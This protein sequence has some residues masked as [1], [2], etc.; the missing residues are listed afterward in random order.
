VSGPRVAD[1]EYYDNPF[2]TGAAGGA[3]VGA[4]AG[5]GPGSG[6]VGSGLGTV[7]GIA[8]LPGLVSGGLNYLSARESN[9]M[10]YRIFKEA[11]EFN[12]GE[13][14]INRLFQDSQGAQQRAFQERMSSTAYQ[15]ATADMKAAGIN[16][17]LA[18]MQGGASS[19]SG[20]SG[21]GAQASSGSAHMENT[22]MGD[23]IKES[24][25]TAI[26]LS[27]FEK[28]MQSMDASISLDKA[29]ASQ[30]MA[31]E[32][33]TKVSAKQAQ[34]TLPAIKEEAKAR[35]RHGEIDTTL[36][37]LDAG[38]DRLGSIGSAILSPI[39]GLFGGGSGK[40]SMS[41]PEAHDKWMKTRP[42]PFKGTRRY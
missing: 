31:E 27:R 17:M 16:P 3:N 14:R 4:N 5:F 20:A 25:A 32:E 19:P 36:A 22:R 34:A 33:M 9:D 37:P 23:S 12:A 15:R 6:S 13:A 8:G 7:G 35:K 42:Q 28:E 2:P 39:R 11:Q 40:K 30:A 41:Y 29:R 24:L 26:Q 38:I 18:Y 1:Q 21:S 10:N